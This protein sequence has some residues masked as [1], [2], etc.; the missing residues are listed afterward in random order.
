MAFDN[1]FLRDSRTK[2]NSRSGDNSRSSKQ[3]SKFTQF[4]E[5]RNAYLAQLSAG[6]RGVEEEHEHEDELSTSRKWQRGFQIYTNLAT[7]F[8]IALTIIQINDFLTYTSHTVFRKMRYWNFL[9]PQSLGLLFLV[10]TLALYFALLS[11]VYNLLYHP[12]HRYK[13]GIFLLVYIIG[14]TLVRCFWEVGMAGYK[15]QFSP[16]EL[17]RT[18]Y[19]NRCG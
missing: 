3:P 18:N 10:H 8:T 2:T 19:S 16:E 4:D 1:P 15:P 5:Q 12:K 9:T 11:F 14:M 17:Y 7:A 6:Y 13:R